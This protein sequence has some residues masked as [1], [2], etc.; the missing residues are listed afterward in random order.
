VQ[1][2]VRAN[3]PM[4]SK[5]H[6]RLLSGSSWCESTSGSHFQE[7][8]VRFSR[9]SCPENSC[10]ATAGSGVQI[11]GAPPFHPC[12]S[13][14]SEP[15][16][17]KG[18][19]A[20]AIA[21][22]SWKKVRAAISLRSVL[23]GDTNACMVQKQHVWFSTRRPRSITG[24]PARHPSA[25]PLHHLGGRHFH[26]SVAQKQSRRLITG[27]PRSVTSRRDHFLWLFS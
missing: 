5:Q 11:P 1:V 3:S 20:S 6:V 9:G 26:P 18:Q 21:A 23:A 13:T 27:R 12:S 7:E 24:S 4:M 16:S 25:V 2:L 15:S 14:D 19:D 22:F 8:H 10:P 17:P